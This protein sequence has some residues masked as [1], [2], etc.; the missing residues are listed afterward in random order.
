MKFFQYENMSVQNTGFSDA[1]KI[2]KKKIIGNI[3]IFFLILL[4]NKENGYTPV[5][6]SFTIKGGV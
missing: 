4:K 2:E 3:L 5:Y 1:V 6:P